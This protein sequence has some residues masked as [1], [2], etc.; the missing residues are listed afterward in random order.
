MYKCEQLQVRFFL[1]I[2]HI[3]G[4]YKCKQLILV[5]KYK[6]ILKKKITILL[7]NT[8]RKKCANN[9]FVVVIY[10]DLEIFKNKFIVHD[11]I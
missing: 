11:I 8:C 3:I 4:V 2:F 10:I 7:K 5:Y 6:Q 9:L 1:M